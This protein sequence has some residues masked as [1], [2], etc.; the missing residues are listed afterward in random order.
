MKSPPPITS[1]YAPDVEQ[2]RAWL[3]RMIA[4]L[5]FVEL[6]TV[7]VAFIGRMGVINAELTKQLAH[8]RRKRPKS[9]T[10]ERLER[11]LTL[12]L[13][14]IAVVPARAASETSEP[15]SKTRERG[16]H[17]G[18]AAP[19]A[20]LP[21][22]TIVNP[23]PPHL[24]I[25]PLCGADMT[26]V[27]HSRCTTIDVIPAKAIVIERLDERVACPKDNSIVSAPTPPAIVERGKLGDGLIIEAVCDKYL[28]HMPV[29]RQCARWG[30]YGVTIAPPTLG[31][32]VSAAIDLLAPVARAIRVRTRAP[33]LLAMDGTGIPVLDPASPDGIRIGTIWCWTNARWV[34]FDYAAKGDSAS[35]R[36]FLGEENLA[37]TIQC[38]GTNI[39]TFV[40]RVG[41]KRPGCWSHGRRR[42]AEAARSY[43][44]LEAA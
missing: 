1:P 29:E 39:M 14:V 44:L 28:D 34:T 41:G 12:P 13:G 21:W 26:T 10:L 18:R 31:R 37:R 23:V 19:P 38:D 24:R 7:I 4:A 2:V 16:A 35:V 22:M 32:S 27:G 36:K 20:H 30:T 43:P 40:E 17:P 9:E 33:G 42:L 3:E 11:Q 5:K 8:L 15:K 25:C 6:V